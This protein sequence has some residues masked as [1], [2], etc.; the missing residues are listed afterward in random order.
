MTV[1]VADVFTATCRL[2]GPA[3]AEC[4]MNSSLT[5]V[6]SYCTLLSYSIRHYNVI[7]GSGGARHRRLPWRHLKAVLGFSFWGGGFAPRLPSRGSAPAPSLVA[8]TPP[9]FRQFLDLLLIDW[10]VW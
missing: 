8:Q 10:E 3:A 7:T 2:V 6:W 1:T 9:I 5:V 4:L